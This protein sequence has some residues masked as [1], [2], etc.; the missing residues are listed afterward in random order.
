MFLVTDFNGESVT[1]KTL[2]SLVQSMTI[3]NMPLEGAKVYHYGKQF[4]ID[5]TIVKSESP[6]ATIDVDSS[7]TNQDETRCKDN[8]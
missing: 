3:E 5:L 8:P 6:R 4:A 7:I 2:G 1:A